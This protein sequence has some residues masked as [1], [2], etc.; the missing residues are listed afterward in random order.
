[1]SVTSVSSAET[2]EKLADGVA[3]VQQDHI[4][5]IYHGSGG[6]LPAAVPFLKE[7]L[8]RHECCVYVADDLEPSRLIGELEAAGIDVAAEQARGA[9]VLLEG[10]GFGMGDT[11]IE[12]WLI[13]LGDTVTQAK[14]AGF[15]GM[16]IAVDMTWTLTTGT[17]L[18]LVQQMESLANDLFY[19]DRP[20]IGMCQYNRERFSP[21]V[22]AGALAS[23]PMAVVEGRVYRT[24]I[25][26]RPRCFSATCRTK[27]AF[28]GC[29]TSS[30]VTARSR[31]SMTS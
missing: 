3:F 4:C 8:E 10:S 30:S 17:N 9:W 31:S 15:T 16:R 1:M 5:H 12:E 27:R 25:T 2:V 22:L 26:G 29:S 23:H 24:C 13:S 14:D 11:P 19:R 20:V 28:S 21:E 7:G 18:S 6:Q